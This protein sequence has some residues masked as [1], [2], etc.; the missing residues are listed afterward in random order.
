MLGFYSISLQNQLSEKMKAVLERLNEYVTTAAKHQNRMEPP[1]KSVWVRRRE[2]DLR[3][4]LLEA[5]SNS[6]F[7]FRRNFI[8]E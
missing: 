7:E 8:V 5:L 3:F 1:L 2:R 6:F 4:E